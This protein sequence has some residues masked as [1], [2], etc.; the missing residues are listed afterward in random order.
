[1]RNLL[2]WV[3]VTVIVTTVSVQ[4]ADAAEWGVHYKGSGASASVHLYKTIYCA[5]QG[6]PE[7]FQANYCQWVRGQV[8]GEPYNDMIFDIWADEGNA[9]VKFALPNWKGAMWDL[10]EI[11]GWVDIYVEGGRMPAY[12]MSDPN[13]ADIYIIVDLNEW[14]NNQK[15][16]QSNYNIVNG[17]CPDLP[18]YLIGTTPIVYDGNAPESGYPFS[19]TTFTGTLYLTGEFEFTPTE[20]IPT[21][22]Q[23][24]LITM[25]ALLAGL[26]IVMIRRRLRPVPA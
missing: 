24:G 23:W 20:P 9:H 16:S 26:G 10:D 25:A 6:D 3:L 12:W 1:M 11:V 8:P 15:P 4:T 2:K 18:G 13:V 7:E 19:T 22:S 14:N 21:L 17:V 5:P